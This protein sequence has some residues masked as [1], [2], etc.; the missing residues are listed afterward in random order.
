[1]PIIRFGTVSRLPVSGG[2]G[3][4]GVGNAAR[5][6]GLGKESM[7]RDSRVERSLLDRD[8]AAS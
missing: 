6:R 4:T 7:A 1:V 5:D 3:R 2:L 8:Y